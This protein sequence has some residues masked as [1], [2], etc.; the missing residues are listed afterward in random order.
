MKKIE[1]IGK[2]KFKKQVPLRYMGRRRLNR[3]VASILDR[4]Y[5]PGLSEKEAY[6]FRAMGFI[7]GD[8]ILDVKAMRRRLLENNVG[9][10]YNEQTKEFVL[11]TESRHTDYLHSMLL[12]HELRHALQDQYFDLASLMGTFSDFDDRKLAR[13]AAIEG[14][15]TFIMLKCSDLDPELLSSNISSGALLSFSPVPK[16][17]LLHD[18]PEIIK[19][20]LIMPYV[21]G[22]RFVCYVFK[23]K[24]IKG[25]NKILHRPPL[26]T[27]Q[28][29]HPEKYF[30]KEPPMP[31]IVNYRP[32]GYELIHSGV[33]GEY[34]LNILLRP[35]NDEYIPDSAAGW[36][37]DMFHLYKK[38]KYYFY[39]W[40]SLWDEITF[41]NDF[42]TR[43]KHYLENRYAVRFKEGKINDTPFI[44]GAG[45]GGY[46]FLRK[47]EKKI[48]YARSDNREQM[49]KFIYGGTYD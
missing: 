44:A 23:K 30:L 36:G 26:S 31:V 13:L 46:F 22:L 18:K 1:R 45:V 19:Y 43:Y 38:D 10:I 37:G 24:G 35:N 7:R 4:E 3:Y 42:Y 8:D 20:Q 48:F 28:I 34:M 17:A 12:V 39:T 47:E 49:N 29:L 27:E 15:A 41:C 32:E 2:L 9:G 40:E 5:S 16:P 21:E 11:A 6:Y 14:D 25:V 33:I